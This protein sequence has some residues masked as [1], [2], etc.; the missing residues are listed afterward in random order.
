[1]TL[2]RFKVFAAVAKFR[3]VTQAAEQ[4]HLSQPA[5]TKHLTTLQKH[6][7]AKLYKR[8][9]RGIELTETGQALLKE[10]KVL[11][12][13]YER[14]R[15][16]FGVNAGPSDVETLTVGASYS[17]SVELLPSV[18]DRFR[19]T[20]PRVHVNLRTG[21]RF[22]IERLILSTD[23]DLAVVTNAPSNSSLVMEPYRREPLMAFVASNHPLAGRHQ[24]TV[25]EFEQVPLI[26][27]RGWKGRSMTEEL[28][29]EAKKMG[30]AP[31]IAMRCEEPAAVKAVVKR[32]MGV[33]ILLKETIED[34]IRRGEFKTVKLPLKNFSGQSFLV[35]RKDKSLSKNAL[36]FLKLLR[37]RQPGPAER[38]TK[39]KPA[40]NLS[41]AVTVRPNR[42]SQFRF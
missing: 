38:R 34:E 13:R 23:V 42:F 31:K 39:R 21:D 14:I 41:M 15:V 24:L 5:V 10:V 35:Y 22:T 7:L 19:R 4:L 40:E 36:D 1:M 27:R 29:E 16:K 2:D 28:L 18:V 20:H 12:K 32:R 11:L 9:G 37:E 26:I 3:S 25:E 6:C 30:L 33:G 17:P 8:V